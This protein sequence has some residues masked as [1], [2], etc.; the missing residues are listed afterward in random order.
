VGMAED[1]E[2]QLASLKLP[3]LAVRL[4][5]DWFGPPASLD[6]LL[7]KLGQAE[8][9]VDVITP[10]DLDGRS[11]DHFGWMKAPAPIAT[12]IAAWVA[13]RDTAFT[14]RGGSVA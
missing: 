5:D 14:A 12:R 3:V 11:A 9:R 1:F 8:C 13:A 2:Q 10:Q 7:G 6:W 4:R